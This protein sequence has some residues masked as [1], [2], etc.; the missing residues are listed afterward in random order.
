MLEIH[1]DV[2]ATNV[3]R[4]GNDR[5][6]IELSD[7][8]ASRDTVEVWHDNV[9]QYHVVFGSCVHLVHSLKTVELGTISK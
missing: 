1:R 3:R 4:H 9:H 8:V 2:I 6:M 5:G 7:Q